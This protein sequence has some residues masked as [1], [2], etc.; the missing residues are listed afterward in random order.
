MSI[1]N[2]GK[3]GLDNLAVFFHL[4]ILGELRYLG[5]HLGKSQTNRQPIGI[6]FSIWSLKLMI[7]VDSL[8]LQQTVVTI[9]FDSFSMLVHD[10]SAP[11][12]LPVVHQLGGR[13]PMTTSN[14]FHTS[15]PAIRR[16]GQ[17]QYSLLKA[18]DGESSVSII[19]H[20]HSIEWRTEHT[21]MRYD[22]LFSIKFFYLHFIVR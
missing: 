7:R 11:K 10:L 14:T 4:R 2:V 3:N 6:A 21:Y 19:Y 8:L 16:L 15:Q 20:R 9:P 17:P 18:N 5:K 13:V 22:S 12:Q 1:S